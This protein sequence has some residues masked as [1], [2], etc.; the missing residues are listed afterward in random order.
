[1]SYLYPSYLDLKVSSALK[2]ERLY[3]VCIFWGKQLD[4]IK[5]FIVNPKVNH[6]HM[7]VF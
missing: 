7:L 5:F 3:K 1:M 4:T 6:D 2:K